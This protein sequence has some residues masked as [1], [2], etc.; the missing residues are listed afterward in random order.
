MLRVPVRQLHVLDP[1]TL[2]PS[3]EPIC[4]KGCAPHALAV[5]ALGSELFVADGR[6]YFV[7]DGHSGRFEDAPT[8]VV[9][10]SEAHGA[11]AD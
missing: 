11:P 7:R 9:V 1:E 10:L 6:S 2:K 8:R 4:L 3:R 5:V